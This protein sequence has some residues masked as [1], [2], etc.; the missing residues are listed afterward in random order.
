MKASVKAAGVVLIAL[1]MVAGAAVLNLRGTAAPERPVDAGVSSSALLRPAVGA[2]SLERSIATLQER[3][4][5]LPND[6]RGYAALGLAYVA[7]ARVTADPSFYPRAEGALGES[8]RLQREDNVDAV[9][10]LGALA[11]ARHDFEAALEHGRAAEALNAYDADVY[12]VIGDALL[13]LGRYEDAF[14]T[15]QTMVDTRP[16]LA[17]YARASYARELLGDVPGAIEAMERAFAAAGT[18][19]DA[20]WAARQLG[21]L[22]LGRGDVDE[23]AAWFERGLGLAPG[24]VPN[25]A[26][27]A[28]VAWARGETELAVERYREAVARYPAVE[29]VAALG[30]LYA[31][32]G[33][34]DLAAEQYAVVAATRDLARESGVNVDLE[35]ALF[36]ADH[37]D[38]TAAL[39]AAE[40]E[41]AR[42][43]SIH[44]ADAYAWALYSNGRDEDAERLSERAL[45]LG[46][47][48]ATF[49][50]HAAMI[51]RALGHDAAARRL[52][53][54]AMALNPYFS[55]L[56]APTAE[57]VLAELEAER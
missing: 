35:I 1:A 56:H 10:G 42:R 17:S 9:L 5:V 50:F 15:F 8:L 21:D 6:W 7:Q 4:R 12:G 40:A 20:A 29:D 52:L 24:Y 25:L 39:V 11:L 31:S 36:D 37:G 44:V 34:P 51:Q 47:R 41:W 55:I 22:E 28:R 27:L 49:L 3:L 16:D 2:G 32:T 23:A 13:E 14:A 19:A 30:D 57:R 53:H 38:P 43:E 26:G 33:R 48:N 46:T 18:P 45:A 54:D